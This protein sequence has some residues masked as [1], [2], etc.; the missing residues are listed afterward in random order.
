MLRDTTI[1]EQGQRRGFRVGR[2]RQLEAEGEGVGVRK[3]RGERRVHEPSR[4]LTRLTMSCDEEGADN[5]TCLC[6]ARQSVV[7]TPRQPN[8]SD[9]YLHR[10]HRSRH[11]G[12]P[13]V[14][15]GQWL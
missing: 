3:M 9:P 2:E 13:Q 7:L 15:P 6:A 8:A 14:P 12:L 5:P 10:P 1:Q 4:R 11:V